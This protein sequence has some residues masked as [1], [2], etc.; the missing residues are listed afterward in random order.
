MLAGWVLVFTTLAPAVLSAQTILALSRCRWQGEIAIKRWKSVLDVDALRAKAHS[1]LAEVWRHGKGLDA[2]MRERRMR[3][4]LGASW[5]RLDHE[6]L[7][8]WWRVWGM[9]KDELAPRITSALFW[10]EEARAA[11]LKV[12]AER[13]RRRTLPQL[14]P[15]AIDVL[16]RC[17]ASK[18]AGMP[19][20]A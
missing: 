18:Q 15:E 7:G 20:A 11:C 1:P 19:I 3:R 6:R 2:W 12:L 17:D 14:P 13:P 10:K 9:R 4:Q 5:G 8:T 16:Y